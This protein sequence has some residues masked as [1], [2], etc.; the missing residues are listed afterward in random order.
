MNSISKPHIVDL[1]RIFDKR[2]YISP[3]IR[4]A[5][6]RSKPELIRDLSRHFRVLQTD[7]NIITLK[8]MKILC[9]VPVIQYHLKEKHYTF[10]GHAVDV[11]RQS[12]ERVHFR[13]SRVPVTIHFPSYPVPPPQS[14][15]PSIRRDS[16]SSP[17]SLERDTDTPSGN[18]SRSAPSVDSDSIP[19]SRFAYPLSSDN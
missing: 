2:R 18:S 19:K 3:R 16:V 1:L 7:E 13:I 9:E 15:P 11:P 12:R 6:V 4:Y 8:P 5:S 17:R 10:D 14:G